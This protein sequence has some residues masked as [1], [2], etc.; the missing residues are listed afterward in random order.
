M[1]PPYVAQPCE[2]S[3]VSRAV[4]PIRRPETSL[5]CLAPPAR[6]SCDIFT[7]DR[8]NGRAEI[9]EVEPFHKGLGLNTGD[10]VP[11]ARDRE[12]PSLMH[13]LG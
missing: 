1:I 7:C 13:A 5:T 12:G 3:A 11:A 9:P 8:G 10:P 2:G 4:P 6:L